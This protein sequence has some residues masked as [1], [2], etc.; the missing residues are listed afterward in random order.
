M[1]WP[2]AQ[3]SISVEHEPDATNSGPDPGL[4]LTQPSDSGPDLPDIL[5]D[6]CGETAVLNSGDPWCASCGLWV[7]VSAAPLAGGAAVPA[8]VPSFQSGASSLPTAPS[9]AALAAPLL[10]ADSWDLASQ[11][12][13]LSSSQQG[14]RVVG[15]PP[16]PFISG[17]FSALYVPFLYSAVN[18]LSEN[19]NAAWMRD[20]RAHWFVQFRSTLQ[21][22]RTRVPVGEILAFAFTKEGKC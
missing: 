8:Q 12:P 6:N 20:P 7:E 4:P 21:A 15:F 18:M 14:A 22:G 9:S 3:P 10:Q 5:C 1:L 2:A 13:E 17:T 19:E 11:L 16:P